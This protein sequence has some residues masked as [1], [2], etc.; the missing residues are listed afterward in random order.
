MLDRARS[1]AKEG[2]DPTAARDAWRTLLDRDPTREVR[3]E[4]LFGLGVAGREA[5]KYDE[6]ERAFRDR[7]SFAGAGTARAAESRYQLAWVESRRNRHD[8][9]AR[10]MDAAAENAN[11]PP[12]LRAH[13]LTNGAYFALQ[14]GD[15]SRARE[16]LAGL[17]DR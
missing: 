17:D 10:G 9:A 3:D 11:G 1:L 7:M 13:A 6:A 8:A 12:T 15:E 16:M 2:K 14:A 4:A 5:G